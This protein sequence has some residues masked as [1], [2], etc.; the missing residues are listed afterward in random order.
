MTRLALY[1]F[2]PPRLEVDGNPAKTDRRKA[3]ALLAYLA[4]TR[5]SQ[6]R[7]KLAAL[8][9]PDYEPDK[10]FAYLRRTLWE[11]NQLV[12]EG[13]VEADRE[14]VTLRDGCWLDVAEFQKAVAGCL[15]EAASA[16]PDC[17][18]RLT[19]AVELYRDHF[20]SGFNLKDAPE[21]DEWAFFQ[22]EGLRRDLAQAL[23]TLTRHHLDEDDAQAALPFARRW[24]SLDTLNEAAHRWLLRAYERAGQHAAALRQYEE[25]ARHLQEELGVP[26]SAET[27]ALYE[28]I[29]QGSLK[30][31]ARPSPPPSPVARIQAAPSATPFIGRVEELAEIT[32]LL[33]NPE[34]RLLTLTGPGG[35]GKTRLA[36]QAAEA[37][38][39]AFAQGAFF[40][41]LAPLTEPAFIVPAIAE[42]IGFSFFS[43]VAGD[44]RPMQLRQLLNFLEAKQMLLVLD[45]FE[46]LLPAS[47]FLPDLLRAAPQIKLLI[48]SR[49]RLNLQDEWA[50]AIRGM[51]VPEG[52]G[53]ETGDEYNAIQLFSQSARRADA[54]FVLTESDRPFVIRIC[55]LVEGLPLGIELAAAWVK[56]LSCREIVAE[57]ERSLDFLTTPLGD[58]PERHQSLRAVFDSS[59]KL[60]APAE[61]DAFRRLSVFHGGFDRK[62]AQ[63]VSGASLGMLSALVDKSLLYRDLAGRYDQHEAVRQYAA[64]QLA[65]APEIREGTLARHS[66]HYAGYVQ[67]W[68]KSL[69]GRDQKRALEEIGGEIENVR[70]GF[71][72]GVQAGRVAE[73]DQYLDGLFWFYDI[74]SRFQEGEELAGQLL[75]IWQ[76]RNDSALEAAI[77]L[78]KLLAWHSWFCFRLGRMP[79]AGS[80]MRQS[81]Q[82][83]R[84]LGEPARPAL[85]FV[86]L[87]ALWNFIVNTREEAEPMV[88]FSRD[89]YREQNDAWGLATLHPYTA[90][91]SPPAEFKKAI[92]ES[93]A[94]LRANGDDR[95]AAIRLN[96]L[97]EFV[98]HLGE[99]A[100]ARRYFQESLMLSRELG[101]RWATSLAL[102]YAGWVARQMGDYAEAD[103]QHKESLAISREIGDQLG[104]AGSLDNLGLI[105]FELG[106]YP[107]AERLF[108][109]ALSLRRSTGHIWSIGLSLTQVAQWA[110]ATGDLPRAE[111]ALAEGTTLISDS[112]L[113][114][115]TTGD[116]CLAQGDV[117][118][119]KAHYLQAARS[120]IQGRTFW[121]AMKCLRA[122]SRALARA[123][124]TARA[125]EVLAF[126]LHHPASDYVTLINARRQM[127]EAAQGL[128]DD[129]RTEAEARGRAMTLEA[130]IESF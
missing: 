53:P 35:V 29:K 25:C 99:F 68:H 8:L 100:E 72:W 123:G 63:A 33:A 36:R 20:L 19:Q 129:V 89:Y 84:G 81:L 94:M 26:P 42:A 38:S 80:Q 7:E 125:I 71:R 40:V 114:I 30:K 78:G 10:A 128:L 1:L 106:R 64:E 3:V 79:L 2:G 102:D 119:A 130:L 98:H 118:T 9:W 15:G 104:V 59:W 91:D 82:L 116:V 5:Q 24:L 93:V 56:S 122:L 73:T 107:E 67:A 44:D 75:T 121:L 21:F 126:V 70:A 109:E 55:Q 115:K 49:E 90:F 77:L 37:Q 96:E 88:L 14:T 6:G 54:R 111:Q 50:L 47:A 97:G 85:A 113:L 12:G 87:L 110:L 124:Q 62:A 22:A 32:S 39:E 46:H 120:A 60:L 28:Q 18:P 51:R 52:E 23:E 76:R 4:L 127:E 66:V 31:E 65:A 13:W 27:S 112:P 86:N 61:Q 74:R 11:I 95:S 103:H 34:C 108:M 117:V 69:F 57:I 43:Q 92:L 83:L 16:D 48:T 41:P 17:L 101:D 58:V 105:P 45:N